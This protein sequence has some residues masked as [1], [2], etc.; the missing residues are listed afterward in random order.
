[1]GEHIVVFGILGLRGVQ[2]ESCADSEVPRIGFA[3]CSCAARG[4]VREKKGDA[5]SGSGLEE[6]ALLCSD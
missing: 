2:I 5:F 6:I 3:R 4:G 1:M